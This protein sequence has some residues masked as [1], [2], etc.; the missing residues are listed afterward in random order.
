MKRPILLVAVMLGAVPPEAA[1]GLLVRGDVSATAGWFNAHQA[2]L[3]QYNDWYNSSAIGEAGAGWYWTDHWK[4]EIMAGASSEKTAYTSF[5]VT[6]GGPPFY[7]SSRVG[8]LTRRVTVTQQY[9]FGDNQW[10][11]GYLGAGV[12][13]VWRRRSRRDDPLPSYDPVLRQPRPGR[14]PVFHPDEID[15]RALPAAAA[16]FKAYVSRRAFVRSDVRVTFDGRADEVV[17]RLGLGVD[18]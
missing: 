17:V 18:F 8:F 7:I 9:Q 1:E 2:E 13:A 12:D 16:G 14:G 5:L 10:F 6:E 3:G 4:T 11:H 15:I